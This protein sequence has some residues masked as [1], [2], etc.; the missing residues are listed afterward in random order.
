LNLVINAIDALPHGGKIIVRSW[1]KDNSIYISVEDNGSGIGDEDKRRIFDPF[2][3]TKGVK[4]VGLGLSV[5]YGI[6]TRYGGEISVQSELNQGSTFVI[7]LPIKKKQTPDHQPEK[8]FIKVNKLGTLSSIE[9]QQ[10]KVTT[11]DKDGYRP[12]P[13]ER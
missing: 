2:F 5:A 6:I 8:S 3:T 7:K 1:K 11:G 13:E 10:M 4:G 12:H 9:K